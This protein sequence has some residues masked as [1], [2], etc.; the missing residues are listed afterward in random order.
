MEAMRRELLEKFGFSTEIH[1]TLDIY[2]T[3]RDNHLSFKISLDGEII[4]IEVDV[5]W[6]GKWQ[7]DF[8]LYYHLDQNPIQ[9]VEEIVKGVVL[10]MSL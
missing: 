6:G 4:Q 5:I 8:T 7:R 2:L 9:S 10:E 1:G 3:K